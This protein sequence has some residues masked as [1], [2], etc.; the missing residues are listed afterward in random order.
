MNTTTTTEVDPTVVGFVVID[1]GARWLDVTTES[2]DEPVSCDFPAKGSD[3]DALTVLRE[4]GWE[5]ALGSRWRVRNYSSGIRRRAVVRTSAQPVTEAHPITEFPA[6]EGRSPVSM[7]WLACGCTAVYEGHAV[8]VG[9]VVLCPEEP[10]NCRGA[11]WLGFS[12]VTSTVR[13]VRF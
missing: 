8:A 10:G 9:T 2:E 3:E 7:C 12:T 4:A 1:P 5:P 6:V 11:S 13:T